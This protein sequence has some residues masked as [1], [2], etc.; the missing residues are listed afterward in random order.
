ME[1]LLGVSEE[2]IKTI[3]KLVFIARCNCEEYQNKETLTNEEEMNYGEWLL[4]DDLFNRMQA[5]INNQFIL[6]KKDLSDLST[7][8]DRKES[9]GVLSSEEIEC[10]RRIIKELS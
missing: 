5:L 4:R 7:P 2:D 9:S 6:N 10:I 3:N 1:I 8:D